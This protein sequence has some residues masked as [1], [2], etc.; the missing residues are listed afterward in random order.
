MFVPAKPREIGRVINLQL[1]RQLL[2]RPLASLGEGQ[3]SHNALVKAG[4]CSSTDQAAGSG[5]V[6][7]FLSHC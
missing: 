6:S 1:A 3:K 4:G 2:K 7:R 5:V